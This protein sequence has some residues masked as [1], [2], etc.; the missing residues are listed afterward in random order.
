MEKETEG[1]PIQG[2]DQETKKK[3]DTQGGTFQCCVCK[4]EETFHC[5]GPIPFFC[6]TVRLSADSYVARDPFTPLQQRSFLLLGSDCGVCGNPVCQSCS[7]YY[8][9][10]FCKP[11]ALE[12]ASKF[13]APLKARILQP[14][15]MQS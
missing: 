5:R 15:F 7:L 8:T 2:F 13:P 9:K 14:N 3:E 11:C 10:R 6:K 1:V 4:L 12:T